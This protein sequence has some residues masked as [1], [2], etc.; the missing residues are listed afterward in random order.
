[1]KKII[2]I[3]LAIAVIGTGAFFF[4]RHKMKVDDMNEKLQSCIGKDQGLTETILKTE[5]ESSSI[6]YKELFELCE[7]SVKDRTDM[8]IELRGLY[9]NLESVLRDS[10][11]GFL[12]SENELI[13]SKSQSYRKSMNLGTEYDSFNDAMSDWRTSSSSY[14]TDYYHKRIADSVKEIVKGAKGLKEDVQTFY[15]TFKLLVEKEKG[16]DKVM[17]SE[18]LRFD[19]IFGKYQKSTLKFMNDQTEYADLLL[20]KFSKEND[21]ILANW[22]L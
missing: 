15:D 20:N 3:T 7:K 18:G 12:N 11:V 4:I 17:D 13:R 22:K 5:D 19:P 6:S 14:M 9:P 2:L 8:L 21:Y 10:L 1:M 16:L